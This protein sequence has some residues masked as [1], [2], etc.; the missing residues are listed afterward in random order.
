M[1]EYEYYE[2]TIEYGL[3]APRHVLDFFRLFRRRNC[4]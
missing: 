1:N 4:I 3:T 2:L